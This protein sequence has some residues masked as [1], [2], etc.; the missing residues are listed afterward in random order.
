MS[1]NWFIATGR[2]KT[3]IARVR[4]KIGVGKMTINGKEPE[5]YFPTKN[6]VALI[7]QPL[8]ISNNKGKWDFKINVIGGGVFRAGRSC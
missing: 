8:E 4:V 3:A 2:R 5:T 7:K 6:D 1:D